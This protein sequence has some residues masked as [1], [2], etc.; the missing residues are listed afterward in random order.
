M[1][2]MKY[3]NRS[4]HKGHFVMRELTSHGRSRR[5]LARAVEGP[6]DPLSARLRQVLQE[7]RKTIYQL[8][9]DTGIDG[10]Y[11]WRIVRGERVEVSREVLML[12]SVAMVLDREQ[13]DQ[14]VEMANRLLDAGGYK[15]LRGH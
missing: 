3:M 10:T 6:H 5:P 14:V 15:V 11:L 8:S 12:I 7:S 13:A 9:A 4:N 1:A 2:I